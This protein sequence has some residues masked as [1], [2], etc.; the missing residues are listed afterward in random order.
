[1]F[2]CS[3]GRLAARQ[4][5]DRMAGGVAEGEPLIGEATMLKCQGILTLI[6]A[7]LLLSLSS[8]HVTGQDTKPAKKSGKVS[9]VLISKS[10][11]S[12]T[13]HVDK[14]EEPAK[15]TIDEKNKKQA[16][17]LKTVYD[18]GRV[19][20]TYKT[21]GDDRQLVLIT[22]QVLQQ[23]GTLTGTVVKVHNDFWVEVK[24]KSGRY[25]GF[26]P[27]GRN[28]KDKAFMDRLKALQAGDTV[29]VQFTTDSERH[30]IVAFKK[31]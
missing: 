14:E 19:Q 7:V 26:A 15:Y 13:V 10:S 1:M 9:G 31:K 22:R 28:N 25:E 11:D 30:R 21:E 27:N 20:L 3:D 6:G 16:A 5:P 12:I 18:G 23:S 29:T 4:R 17:A 8:S 24:L 2:A